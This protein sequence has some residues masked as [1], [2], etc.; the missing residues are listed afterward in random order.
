MVN[1]AELTIVIPAYRCAR[2]L[3]ATVRSAL[4]CAGTEILIAEDASGDGTV[5]V[6]RQINRQFPDRVRLIENTRNL[7]MTAN[8]RNAFEQVR[9]PWAL[10]LDGDDLINPAYLAAALSI[11]R[12]QSNFMVIAGG[13]EEIG[14]D[15]YLAE[16]PP[17]HSINPESFKSYAGIDALRVC[18]AWTPV[19]CSSSM[20][21]NMDIYQRVGGFASAL[22]WCPDREIW[23]R[24]ARH[25]PIVIC[26]G[27]AAFYRVLPESITAI[28]KRADR[29]C[30]EHSQMFRLAERFW[31]EPA[32][33]K[34]FRRVF[35]RSSGSFVKSAWRALL[36]ARAQ[37]I[38]DR[39]GNG[40]RDLCRAVRSFCRQ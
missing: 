24:L 40:T 6:A 10:K 8:W 39:L 34:L 32:A 31:P 7:G 19:P 18:M 29:Q 20:I 25:G 14:P 26:E 33:R 11:I 37:E 36:R 2:Y 35:F 1:S 12:T 17:S 4:E 3:P 15:A 28:T 16:P 30:F 9:T 27:L 13:L 23:F 22:S 21:F 38:P 5:Q